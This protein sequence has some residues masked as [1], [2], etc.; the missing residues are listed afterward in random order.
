MGFCNLFE[1]NAK[2]RSAL[3]IYAYMG[4]TAFRTKCRMLLILV[5]S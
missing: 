4:I 2:F 3:Y 5:L 1:R